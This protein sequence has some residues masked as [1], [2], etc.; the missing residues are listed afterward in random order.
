MCVCG[1]AGVCVWV[2]RG[3][4]DGRGGLREFRGDRIHKL[5]FLI[6]RKLSVDC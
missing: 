3:A 5:V 4:E 2:C 6:W 1:G